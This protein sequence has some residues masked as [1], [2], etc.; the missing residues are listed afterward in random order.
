MFNS[1]VLDVAIGLIFVFL[2]V[3]L[4]CGLITEA[5]ATIFSWRANT[6]LT[7]VKDMVNDQGF[8]KLARDLYNHALV[9]PRGPGVPAGA[10]PAAA[11][12]AAVTNKPAYIDPQHFAGAMLDTL[13]IVAGS[14]EDM[15]A[16]I[17][18][19][20]LLAGNNQMTTMLTGMADRAGGNIDTMKQSLAAWFDAGMDRVSGNYKRW[21]QLYCFVIGFIIAAGVN[22]DTLQ[23]TASLWQ[24]PQITQSLKATMTPADAVKEVQSLALPVGWVPP[25]TQYPTTCL[26]WS[27]KLLGWAFTAL[28]TLFG[29]SFWFG[30]LS[31]VLK[32]RGSGPSPGDKA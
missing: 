12:A 18:A 5:W 26:A 20:P 27:A 8:T 25:G 10:T 4:I 11:T 2:T 9:N 21:T 15:R 6:L 23:I 16:A 3:S 13:H 28:S 31:G 32:I 24:Q 14:A 19:S 7:G 29:A 1:S 17:T 22:I 30:A